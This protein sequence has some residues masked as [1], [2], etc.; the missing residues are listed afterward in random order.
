MS[1]EL[2]RSM[3]KEIVRREGGF[4]DHKNDAGGATNHGVS[5]RYAKRLGLKF[6]KDHDGDVD[7]DDIRLVT[8]EEAVDLYI[9]D[10]FDAP[11]IDDMPEA[12]WPVMFD[13]A[14]NAGPARAIMLLQEI[15]NEVARLAPE[16]GLSPLEPDGTTGPR[17]RA[18][19]KLLATAMGP[20]LINA[21]VEARIAYYRKLASRDTS[22][23][24]F[25]AGWLNRA[26]E[27]RVSVQ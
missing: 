18:A 4:V 7:A 1:T 6:D 24:V 27:F 25:L 14:V 20:Y 8:P 22:Q 2:I 13:F 11:G 19:A 17:T 10:F 15:V 12:L 21:Y 5:L 9:R 16:L 23:K 3:A 26:N